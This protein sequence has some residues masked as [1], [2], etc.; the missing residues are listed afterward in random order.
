MS[1]PETVT[2]ALAV[3]GGL[4]LSKQTKDYLS[5]ALGQPGK[6]IGTILGAYTH[7]RI[8][9]AK[10]IFDRAHTLLSIGVTPRDIAPN[11]QQP[12]LEA[13]SLQR[14]EYLQDTW[15]NMLANA[16]DPRQRELEPLFVGILADF[17]SREVKFLDVLSQHKMIVR[18]IEER[19]LQKVYFGAK[20]AR[21]PA[22]REVAHFPEQTILDEEDKTEFSIMIDILTRARV[23]ADTRSQQTVITG[24]G[25]AFLKACQK[26]T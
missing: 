6:S 23:I 2:T 26:P 21:K 13:A 8:K 17:T 15:A 1:V 12:A 14:D 9:N 11:I 10:S 19:E 18:G 5:A 24:L 22:P 16:A 7:E 20:L 25:R 4:D 3:I